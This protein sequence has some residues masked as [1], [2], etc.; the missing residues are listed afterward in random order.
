MSNLDSLEELELSAFH[1]LDECHVFVGITDFVEGDGSGNA[2]Y[3]DALQ[4]V[5]DGGA[6]GGTGS[7]DC[8]DCNQVSVIAQRG[9]GGDDFS[10]I[11]GLQVFFEAG[12][13]CA[14]FSS[15]RF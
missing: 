2:F 4:S 15:G 3:R 10:L 8:L 1:G 14:S 13:E 11:V 6:F 12:D 5:F 7:F 9:N